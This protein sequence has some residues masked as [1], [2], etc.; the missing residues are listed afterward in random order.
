MT[1]IE[2]NCLLHVQMK[3]ENSVIFLQDRFNTC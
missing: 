1:L 2:Q 3:Q